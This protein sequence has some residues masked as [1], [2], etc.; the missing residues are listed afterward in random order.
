MG[1]AANGE[2][3]EARWKTYPSRIVYFFVVPGQASVHK[4]GSNFISVDCL[5]GSRHIHREKEV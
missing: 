2:P 1:Y 3:T 5:D 4:F